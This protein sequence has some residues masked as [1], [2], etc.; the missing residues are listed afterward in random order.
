[1]N[2][3]LR[4]QGMDALQLLV[5]EY[6]QEFIDWMKKGADWTASQA[7]MLAQE[8]VVFEFWSSLFLALVA[9]AFAVF[10]VFIFRWSMK[11]FET[12]CDEFFP[13]LG[14]IVSLVFM[15]GGTVTFTMQSYDAIKAKAAPRLV[16][17]EKVVEVLRPPRKN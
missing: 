13:V 5:T 8:I 14:M 9:V 10:G 11:R 3:E 12:T 17:I 16:I 2:E 15:I 1:M 6:L 7:G 4:E